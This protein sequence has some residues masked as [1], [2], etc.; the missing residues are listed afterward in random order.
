[1]TQWL[2]RNKK[3]KIDGPLSTSEVIQG[4]RSGTYFG[5]EFISRYPLRTLAS[6]FP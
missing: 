5:E 3:G 2:V 1:M 4:I 6:Y